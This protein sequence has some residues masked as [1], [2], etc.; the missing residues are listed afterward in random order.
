[1]GKFKPLLPWRGFSL[2]KYQA[3]ILKAAG[4]HD[5]VVVTGYRSK[6]VEKELRTEDVIITRNSD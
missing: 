3:K 4:C 1:M 5:V 2:V 6:D